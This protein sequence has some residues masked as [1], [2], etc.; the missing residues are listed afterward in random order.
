MESGQN[1]DG[2]FVYDYTTG[3]GG[4]PAEV[5]FV[6]SGWNEVIGIDFQRRQMEAY[7]NAVLEVVDGVGHDFPW[8]KPAETVGLV[9]G[10]LER[11][12]DTGREGH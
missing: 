2:D 11:L 1:D 8:V 3:L 4:F 10:Y 7:P 5:L 6:A 9:R 12:D